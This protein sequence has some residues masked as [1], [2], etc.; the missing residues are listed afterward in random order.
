M[1][2]KKKTKGTGPPPA[3]IDAG[4]SKRKKDP[5]KKSIQK[6]RR[7]LGKGSHPK[8]V[9]MGL[10]ILNRYLHNKYFEPRYTGVRL[11]SG[12]WV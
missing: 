4:N 1:E 3:G 7:S 12:Y 10:H 5:L 8:K 2:G 6:G 9:Y 11:R